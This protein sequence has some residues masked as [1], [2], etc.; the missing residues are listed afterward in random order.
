MPPATFRQHR[1]SVYPSQNPTAQIP[2]GMRRTVHG[3][4]DA[5]NWYLQQD[6]TPETV[7][8]WIEQQ[9]KREPGFVTRW[10]DRIRA[11]PPLMVGAIQIASI[12]AIAA[13]S[14]AN[15]RGPKHPDA[16]PSCPVRSVAAEVE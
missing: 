8:G 10:L 16:D 5:S 2:S 1:I 9:E 15:R 3:W 6:E 13:I 11:V 14:S 7:L 4:E 12:A